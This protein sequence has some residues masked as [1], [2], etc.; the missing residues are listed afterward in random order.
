MLAE[1][2]RPVIRHF[3]RS[4]L[5][6]PALLILAAPAAAQVGSSPSRQL[7]PNSPF[8]GGVPEGQP[9]TDVLRLSVIDVIHRALEHNL[10]VLM[11]E[12]S[13]NHAGGARWIALSQLLPNIN[14]K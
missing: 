7:P 1:A 12:E 9:T 4:F 11:A 6:I 13:Q 10:G 2:H 5:I 3:S 14:G 8:M